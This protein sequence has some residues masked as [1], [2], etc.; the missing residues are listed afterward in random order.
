MRLTAGER[1]DVQTRA[2]EIDLVLTDDHWAMI[3]FAVN[4]YRRNQTMCNL[5][6]IVREGDFDKKTAYR[7]FP[8]NPIKRI[9]YLT[10]LPMP[11]EC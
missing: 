10:G 4:Y 1:A 5:R 8:G 9:C 3:E 7:L 2:A 11:P 6:T